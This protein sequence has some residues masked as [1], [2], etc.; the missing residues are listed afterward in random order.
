MVVLRN[1]NTQTLNEH[2]SARLHVLTYTAV[3]YFPWEFA[4][5]FSHCVNMLYLHQSYGNIYTFN[6]QFL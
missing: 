4:R 2:N 5:P 3:I 6:I 1:E